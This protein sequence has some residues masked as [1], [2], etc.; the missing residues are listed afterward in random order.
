M[1]YLIIIFIWV[2]GNITLF[3]QNTIVWKG[4]TPG[5][6]NS[7]NE[8]KNWDVNQIPGNNSHVIIRAINSGHQAQPR[9]ETQVS[10]ASIEIHSGSTLIIGEK[11]EVLLDGEYT[12][13]HGIVNYGGKII[14]KGKIE[15]RNIDSLDV[16]KSK[17]IIAKE[18]FK[19]NS[20][21][22]LAYL[23]FAIIF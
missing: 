21:N 10:V 2:L 12:F 4:G 3:A 18:E 14:N 6:E 7:W 9:I 8:P 1:K 15:L 5:K 19:N 16:Q 17:E 13:S 22:Q 23:F 11:G 20:R